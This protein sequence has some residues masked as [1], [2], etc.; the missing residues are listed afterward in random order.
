MNGG[1]DS[2]LGEFIF[3]PKKKPIQWG[4]GL[5]AMNRETPNRLIWVNHNDLTTTE[6][7]ESLAKKG[8]HSQMVNSD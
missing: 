1:S 8:N 2:E 7:W 5:G 3:P 4:T 6:A